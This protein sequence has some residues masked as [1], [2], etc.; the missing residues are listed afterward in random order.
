METKDAFGSLPES[1]EKECVSEPPPRA[2]ANVPCKPQPAL[3]EAAISADA[4]S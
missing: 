3:P 2:A 1:G 4:L